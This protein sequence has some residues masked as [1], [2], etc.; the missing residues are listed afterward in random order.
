MMNREL[1]KGLQKW[2]KTRQMG[3]SRFV[4]QIGVLAWGIPMFIIMTF[5]VG[6]QSDSPITINRIIGS[7]IIWLIG[8]LAFGLLTWVFSERRYRK[9]TNKE[10]DSK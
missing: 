2:A 8:G 4:L 7:A 1:P 3:K 5:F 10:M 6:P 9:F